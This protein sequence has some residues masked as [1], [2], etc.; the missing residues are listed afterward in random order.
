MWT[1]Y[2]TL[3]SKVMPVSVRRKY[4]SCN[5]HVKKL[6]DPLLC[7]GDKTLESEAFRAYVLAN[8]PWPCA[9][10]TG[11]SVLYVSPVT[12]CKIHMK[13][14]VGI[15]PCK[16]E[17]MESLKQLAILL[18]VSDYDAVPEGPVLSGYLGGMLQ[19]IMAIDSIETMT[20]SEIVA[21]PAIHA[22]AARVMNNIQDGVISQQDLA[23]EIVNILVPFRDRLPKED[24]DEIIALLEAVRD[25]ETL[26]AENLAP[27]LEKFSPN[28]ITM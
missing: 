21:C 14:L 9:L 12:G 19:D 24:A 2:L 17:L 23:G 22:M 27:L 8:R 7:Q 1:T 20:T 10:E 18:E 28:P 3:L 26:T 6:N 5:A 13:N 4:P 25:G 11:A 15:H 16:P